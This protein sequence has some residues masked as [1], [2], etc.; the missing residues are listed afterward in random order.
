MKNLF[1]RKKVII[2]TY[3]PPG[4]LVKMIRIHGK[5]FIRI[6]FTNRVKVQGTW[7]ITDIPWVHVQAIR[8]MPSSAEKFFYGLIGKKPRGRYIVVKHKAK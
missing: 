1:K 4:E 5:K 8:V 6:A 3:F 7:P 2:S